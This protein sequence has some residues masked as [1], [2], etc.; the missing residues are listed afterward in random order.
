[1]QKLMIHFVCVKLVSLD[2]S[3]IPKNHLHLWTFFQ[4]AVYFWASKHRAQCARPLDTQH[5]VLSVMSL[6]KVPDS[7]SPP[8]RTPIQNQ[9]AMVYYRLLQPSRV[10]ES[11]SRQSVTCRGVAALGKVGVGL[12]IGSFD[13]A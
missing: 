10:G 4:S 11:F 1:M 3:L 12:T 5:P 6:N 8:S 7:G 13:I 9:P 2:D